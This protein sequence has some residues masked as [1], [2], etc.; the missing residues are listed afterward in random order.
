[1]QDALY[2]MLAASTGVTPIIHVFSDGK[3]DHLSLVVSRS[4]L[5]DAGLRPGETRAIDDVSIEVDDDPA[6]GDADHD[7]AVLVSRRV[8]RP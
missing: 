1:V 3:E 2:R 5:D 8:S 6:S 7:Y 4:G